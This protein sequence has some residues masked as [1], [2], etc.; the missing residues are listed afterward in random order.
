[1]KCSVFIGCSIDGF[2]AR[3]DGK[4]DFLDLVADEKSDHGYGAFS[5]TTDVMVMGRATYDVV[6]GLVTEWPWPGKRVVVLTHRPLKPR[7]DETTFHG[8]PQQIVAHLEQLGCT[9]AYIDG[10]KVV[11]AF[12]DADLIDSMILSIVPVRLG[13]GIPLFNPGAERKFSLVRVEAFPKGLAQ[14]EYRRER[15]LS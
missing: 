9:H 4:L 15:A 8:T 12:L 1:M 3:P 7:A 11:S 14:L 5:K 2:I 10:G 6:M 13:A